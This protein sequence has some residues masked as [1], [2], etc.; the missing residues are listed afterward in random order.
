M[1]AKKC[2]YKEC[3]KEFSAHHNSNRF[4]SVQH[5][6]MARRKPRLEGDCEYC[7]KHFVSKRTVTDWH[8]TKGGYNLRYCSRTHALAAQRKEKLDRVCEICGKPIKIFPSDAKY[9]RGRFCS[10][11]CYHKWNS[12]ENHPNWNNGSTIEADKLRKSPAYIGWR[13]GVFTRDNRTCVQCHRHYRKKQVEIEADHILPRYFFP[14]LTLDI[15]NGRTLCRKCHKR[16]ETYGRGV[17]G[18]K[19]ADFEKGGQFYDYVL[20]AHKQIGVSDPLA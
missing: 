20:E 9:G 19:R 15:N 1:I 3:G 12:G 8:Y 13:I 2:E 16:T 17:M 4:C 7:N 5:G 6:A 14:E 10:R 11:D 18:L